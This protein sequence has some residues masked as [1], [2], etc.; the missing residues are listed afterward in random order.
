MRLFVPYYETE[1]SDVILFCYT[2]IVEFI[3]NY[4]TEAT[5]ATTESYGS[6]R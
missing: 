4:S 3:M 2:V 5:I 1:I 6:C